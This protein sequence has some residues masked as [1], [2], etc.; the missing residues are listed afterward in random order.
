M[1]TCTHNVFHFLFDLITLYT[2]LAVRNTPQLNGGE[3][4]IDFILPRMETNPTYSSAINTTYETINN[5]Q[6]LS[7]L[8]KDLTLELP[9]NK[10]APPSL[11]PPRS[12]DS[13]SNT[14]PVPERPEDD[15][16]EMNSRSMQSPRY[17]RAPR[18]APPPYDSAIQNGF[19]Y[20]DSSIS[21]Y[22]TQP[23]PPSHSVNRQHNMA[24]TDV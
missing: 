10:E 6:D 17:I 16:V 4:H 11:P 12:N 22:A 24:V 18:T 15:Y 13:A 5:F 21:P 2:F 9:E 20:N 8:K 23:F 19:A 14:Q 7:S 3:N 1:C